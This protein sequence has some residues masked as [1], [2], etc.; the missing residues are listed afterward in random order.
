MK[1]AN[2][3][4]NKAM[5]ASAL[6]CRKIELKHGRRRKIDDTNSLRG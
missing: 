2:D 4:K 1:A 6:Q 5:T 3:S